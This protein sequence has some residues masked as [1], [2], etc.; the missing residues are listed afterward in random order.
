MFEQLKQ[1]NAESEALKKTH[2]EKS[3]ELF[4]EVSKKVFEAHPKLIS[5]GW[6]QYTPYFNDGD[7]C[8]FSARTDKP[9]INDIDGYDVNFGDEFVTDY[10]SSKV[11]GVYPKIKNN[12]FDPD[13]AA[14]LKTVKAFLGEMKDEVLRD[15]FGDHVSVRVTAQGTEVEEYE[16]D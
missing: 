11:N 4:T 9:D 5:F 13:L 8:T 6:R 2:L 14:A 12:S 1:M 7:E 10:N 15:L 3:K 16:H